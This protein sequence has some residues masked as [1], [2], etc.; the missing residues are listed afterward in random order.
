MTITSESIF[1]FLCPSVL[2]NLRA[3]TLL[4]TVCHHV[5]SCYRVSLRTYLQRKVR[6]KVKP[7]TIKPS[8]SATLISRLWMSVNRNSLLQVFQFT[9][10]PDIPPQIDSGAISGFD[11]RYLN[12]V[13]AWYAQN[14]Y[15][16][17]LKLRMKHCSCSLE[18]EQS[19]QPEYRYVLAR[20]IIAPPARRIITS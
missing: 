4:P 10:T 7:T 3:A 12:P 6:R 1:Y 11:C 9:A 20:Y 14:P 13:P 8:Y 16:I 2:F 5:R 18:G 19:C 15:N 17:G